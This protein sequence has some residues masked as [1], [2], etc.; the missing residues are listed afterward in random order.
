MGVI[1]TINVT[2]ADLIAQINL[3]RI[4]D[5]DLFQAVAFLFADATEKNIS[6]FSMLPK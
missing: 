1:D 4:S 5:F 6:L 3:K 2:H